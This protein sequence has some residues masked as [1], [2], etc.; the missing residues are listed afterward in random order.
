VRLNCWSFA[1]NPAG[2]VL[3]RGKPLP[4]LDGTRLVE[5]EG[6]AVPVGYAWSPAVPAAIV[7]RAMRLE[8]D[9]TLVWTADG[10]RRTVA[11]GDWVRATRS[12]VRL[13]RDRFAENASV[14]GDSP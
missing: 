6:I 12:A 5:T 11:A 10:A 13:T 8:K 2:E 7:R 3:V 9:E 14:T 1:L 4:P